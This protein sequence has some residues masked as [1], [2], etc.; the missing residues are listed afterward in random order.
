VE[1][2]LGNY[3]VVR[4][5]LAAEVHAVVHNDTAE[6]F[7]ERRTSE[8]AESEREA[9]LGRRKAVNESRKVLLKSPWGGWNSGGR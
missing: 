2:N 9:R 5:A 6:Q 4:F 7:A 3:F 1:S 8:C